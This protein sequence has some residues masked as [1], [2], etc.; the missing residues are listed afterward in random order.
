M[1]EHAWC[2]PSRELGETG[3]AEAVLAGLDAGE[4]QS[5]EMRAAL[6]SLRLAQHD[7]QG[8]RTALAPILAGS[9]T[10]TH[11]VWAATAALLEAVAQD[12]LGDADA[13]WRA[14]ERAL[15]V[16]EPD[17]MVYPFL[18]HRVP[19]LLESHAR[20]RTAHAALVNDITRPASGGKRGGRTALP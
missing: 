7:P 16:A 13:A 6:A 10:E 17:H 15:D 4:R 19:R 20:R 14:F 5:A 12:A 8:A 18:I 2:R 3:R 9:F 11:R 1:R